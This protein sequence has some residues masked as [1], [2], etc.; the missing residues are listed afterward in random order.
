[1]MCDTRLSPGRAALV[2][3]HDQHDHEAHKGN[4]YACVR[5]SRPYRG[6]FQVGRLLPLDL[7][8]PNALTA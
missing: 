8:H 2:S 4:M 5:C 7:A 1:M 6:A 3:Q